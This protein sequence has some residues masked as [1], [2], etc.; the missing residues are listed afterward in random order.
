MIKAPVE[1]QVGKLG[2]KIQLHR[3]LIR[4]FKFWNHEHR[5][6]IGRFDISF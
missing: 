5:D 4:L 3:K 2:L 6:E 1:L